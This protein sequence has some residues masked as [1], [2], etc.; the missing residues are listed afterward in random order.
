MLDARF[1]ARARSP[2]VLTPVPY[3]P[4]VPVSV[5]HRSLS[6][7]KRFRFAYAVAHR[8]L[9]IAQSS[10]TPVLSFVKCCIPVPNSSSRRKAI[11]YYTPPLTC[12]FRVIEG[13]PSHYSPTSCVATLR[14]HRTLI[15][16]CVGRSTSHSIA[17]ATALVAVPATNTPPC[18]RSPEPPCDTRVPRRL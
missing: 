6:C 11:V 17:V 8:S 7:R 18:P 15:L 10:V 16:P 4:T 2:L 12:T 14:C 1:V 3:A 9:C 13:Q 5:P